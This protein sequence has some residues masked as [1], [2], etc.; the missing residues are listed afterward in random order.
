MTGDYGAAID[1]LT[2]KYGKPEEVKAGP[3]EYT[4][5]G[6]RC[7]LPGTLSPST[8]AQGQRYCRFHYQQLYS[9]VTEEQAALRVRKRLA[10]GTAPDWREA[11]LQAKT[12][13]LQA[14]RDPMMVLAD[15][16]ARGAD[17]REDKVEFLRMFRARLK[18]LGQNE[19]AG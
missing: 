11:D 10:R 4:A 12:V 14:A 18:G 3:C 1:R 6:A 17:N 9:G 13:E 15:Q 8:R 7:T 5:L 2:E 16:L 19:H